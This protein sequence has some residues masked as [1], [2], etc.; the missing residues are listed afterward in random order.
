MINRSSIGVGG[1]AKAAGMALCLTMSSVA[2][3]ALAAPATPN[4]SGAWVLDADAF[5]PPAASLTPAAAAKYNE[6]T[7]TDGPGTRN[8]ARKWCVYVGV[9]TLMQ[10]T[11]PM[12][13]RQNWRQI[14]IISPLR[15]EPR[16]IY[17]D[18]RIQPDPDVYD[19]TTNGFSTSQWRGDTLIVETVG[20][21]DG[22]VLTLPGGGLK[23]QNSRL[24]E[25]FRLVDADTLQVTATWTD[26]TTLRRPHTYTQTFRRVEGQVWFTETYCTP[27]KAMRAVG[28]HL[29]PGEG[30]E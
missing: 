29:P 6:I 25:V 15:A 8:Y 23:S 14:S 26:P 22:G 10:T 12:D 13:I 9:P 30:G 21:N 2:I 17:L 3:P 28:L 16:H 27:V 1:W 19:P 20:F 11:V 7:A 24:R 5:S 4:F 18:P